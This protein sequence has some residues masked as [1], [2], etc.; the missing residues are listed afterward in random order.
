MVSPLLKKELL[1]MATKIPELVEQLSFMELVDQIFKAYPDKKEWIKTETKKKAEA[2]SKMNAKY[3]ELCWFLAEAEL[4][5]RN[6]FSL[7]ILK[8]LSNANTI[9]PTEA[10]I[11]MLAETISTYHNNLPNLEWFLAER[12]VLTELLR[13]Q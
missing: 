7:K 5:L 8:K 13:G 1:K 10:N 9:L 12:Q 4:N 2:H 11:K 3:D 6:A